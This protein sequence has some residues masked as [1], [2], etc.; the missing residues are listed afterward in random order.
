MVYDGIAGFYMEFDYVRV[1]STIGVIMGG[2]KSLN[3]LNYKDT[4]VNNK[5]PSVC[6]SFSKVLFCSQC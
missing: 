4:K 6:F 3:I 2:I 1:Y 5:F